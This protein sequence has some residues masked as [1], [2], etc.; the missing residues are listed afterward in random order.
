LLCWWVRELHIYHTSYSTKVSTHVES[1]WS[2]IHA[3]MNAEYAGFFDI[4]MVERNEG[5]QG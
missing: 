4:G 5:W 3:A 1:D 2:S